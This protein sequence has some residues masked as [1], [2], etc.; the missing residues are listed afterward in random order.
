MRQGDK[1]AKGSPSGYRD[2]KII[3]QSILQR[4]SG[5][6]KLVLFLQSDEVDN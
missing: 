3:H 2:S 6:K 1:K 5:L 4:C